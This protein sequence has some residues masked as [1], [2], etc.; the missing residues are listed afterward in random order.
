[1]LEF[2]QTSF[3]SVHLPRLLRVMLDFSLV[4]FLIYHLLVFVKGTRA[5]QLLLG[6]VILVSGYFVSSDEFLGLPMTNWVFDKFIS[7]FILLF[8]VLF[9][10]EIRWAIART[11]RGRGLGTLETPVKANVVEE[12]VRGCFRLSSAGIGALIV[13]ERS[14]DLNHVTD[15]GV[16]LDMVVTWEALFAIF[17]P[18]RANP[19]HDGAAV[20]RD[21]RIAAAVCFLPLTSN[22]KVDMA[23]GT[24][25]RAAIGLSETSDAIV[26][27]VS[28]E[29]GAVSMVLDGRLTRFNDIKDLRAQL[30]TI[31]IRPASRDS[32]RG[33]Q[34]V[35][36]STGGAA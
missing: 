19:L 11:F 22:P 25:H 21:G 17:N 23:L 26:L 15:G 33:R 14:V 36:A 4:W 3:Q 34:S 2:L 28:E 5:V 24:R 13:V 1:M 29:T 9:Q 8:I 30:A 7:S 6:L 31:L 12:L 10:Q 18:E 27:V 32:A 20:V 16:K 35:P